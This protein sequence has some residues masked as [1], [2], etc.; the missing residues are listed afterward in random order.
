[1]SPDTAPDA[2]ISL[3]VVDDHPV[4][5]D[6]L[7]GMFESAPAPG[8]TVL[9]EAAGGV[10]AVERAVAL[11]PDVVLMDLRMPGGS[12][13]DAI[14][15]LGRRGVR[16]KVLVLTTYDTDSDTL[17]AI[18]AGATGYLLKD[19]PREELFTAVRAAAR[20]R[21]VLS[22]AV[23][24]R[25]VSAVRAPGGEPLSSREREVLAL[26]ARGTSNR[27]IARALF[28]SE[29]TVKTHLTHLYAKLGVKDRAAA[30]AAAYDRGILG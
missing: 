2:P 22:P 18:E 20:G 25:L 3:L 17:P 12:G 7:R 4:V 21:T 13:V 23:A 16:A 28:I 19:A 15:E 11:D 10:E 5:R 9:G 30:V 8:F 27:E 14:R 29:A 6:G 24:T 26:V 1:M